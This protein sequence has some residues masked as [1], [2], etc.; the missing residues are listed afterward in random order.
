M[1]LGRAVR[2]GSPTWLSADRG[3]ALAWQAN[4]RATC[5]GC[6]TRQDEWDDDEHA[7]VS[8]H[9]T[10]PGCLRLAEEAENNLDQVDGKAAPGQHTYL[11]PPHPGELS[12]D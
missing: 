3:Y 8:D 4:K 6:G 5:N 10:C 1:F 12:D 7:Y 11:R 9:F 2:N